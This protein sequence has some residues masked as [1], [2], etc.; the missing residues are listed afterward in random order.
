[1]SGADP[2]SLQWVNKDLAET[3][4][5]ARNLLEEYVERGQNRRSLEQCAER[6]HVVFGVLRMV[7]IY[8]ASL[9]VEEM[10]KVVGY[11]LKGGESLTNQEDAL[12]ALTRAMV[13]LPPYLENVVAGGRD[14]ALVLLPLSE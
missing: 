2:I 7:E 13:Q 12:D 5:E 8:G 4:Q 11:Q 3:I 1:M 6:L 10:E 14:I 9:L